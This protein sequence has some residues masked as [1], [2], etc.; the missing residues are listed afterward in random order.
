[1]LSAWHEVPALSGLKDLSER[2]ATTPLRAQLLNAGP[3][4]L[5]GPASTLETYR[6]YNLTGAG[7]FRASQNLTCLRVWL[8]SFFSLES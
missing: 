6:C 3:A 7:L 5:P 1:M 4:G 8:K 2:P